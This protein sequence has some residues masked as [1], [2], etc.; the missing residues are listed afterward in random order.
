MRRERE[1][2]S[3]RESLCVCVERQGGRRERKRL[4]SIPW[5]LRL[6]MTGII[7]IKRIRRRLKLR[8][9]SPS[10]SL[11]KAKKANHPRT[12]SFSQLATQKPN[13]T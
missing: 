11:E 13:G 3:E 8:S 7:I 5:F 2:E 6:N 1:K 9:K 4:S 10:A 12:E